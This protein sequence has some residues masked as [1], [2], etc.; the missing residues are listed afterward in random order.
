MSAILPLTVEGALTRRRGKVLVG[1]VDLTLGPDG[2][3]I[4]IG[5]N[6]AG[7]TS[8]LRMLHGIARLGAGRLKWNCSEEEARK[9]QAFVFQTP[10]MLR[11]SVRDNLVY[12]LQLHGIARAE[13]R[14][15]AARI[16]GAPDVVAAHVRRR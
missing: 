4:V 8:L 6:G 10:A 13:A 1:P 9:R 15:R 12:P 7:K 5:P 2:V 16:R 11:R 3:T 14:E